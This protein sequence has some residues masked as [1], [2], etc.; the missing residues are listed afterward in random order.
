MTAFGVAIH[1]E[2]SEVALL[3]GLP[4]VAGVGVDDGGRGEDFAGHGRDAEPACDR[5]LSS[6]TSPAVSAFVT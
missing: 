3:A 4:A 6:W 5:L 1:S 2:S